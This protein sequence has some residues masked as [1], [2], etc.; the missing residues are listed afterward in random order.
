MQACKCKAEGEVVASRPIECIYQFSFFKNCSNQQTLREWHYE[1]P[2]IFYLFFKI[3]R[4]WDTSNWDTKD[5]HIILIDPE[6]AYDKVHREV[7][8]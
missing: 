2:F 6:T 3:L 1:I 4:N 5:L 7:M 8:W